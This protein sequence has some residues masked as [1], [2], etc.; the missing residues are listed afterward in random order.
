MVQGNKWTP[1]NTSKP[2]RFKE[3]NV[4]V[5]CGICQVD[6][7]YG[8]ESSHIRFLRV[9]PRICYT[10]AKLCL[11][12]RPFLCFNVYVSFQSTGRYHEDIFGVTLKTREVTTRVRSAAKR[13]E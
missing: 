11:S 1:T 12:D 10:T 3:I 2:G 9:R 6:I 5:V 4:L 13:F 8:K 7:D